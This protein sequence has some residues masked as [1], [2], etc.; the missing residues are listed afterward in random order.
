MKKTREER[1]Q[2]IFAVK[3]MVSREV[4]RKYA[5]SYLGIVW[6]VLNPLM[7]MAVLSLIFSTIFQRSIENYPIYYLTGSLFWHLFSDATSHG[8]SALVDNRAMLLKVKMS[9]QTFVIARVLTALTNF[10]Y[11]FVAYV[12]MLLVFRIR[13][14][15]YII[16]LPIDVFFMFMFAMG[17]TFALSIIYVFFADIKYLYSIFLQLLLYISAL[18]YPVD[19]LSETMQWVIRKNPVYNYIE[20]AR[21]IVLYGIMPEPVLWI[22][23]TLWGVIS[24]V[25]GYIFF[26]KYENLVMQK[27]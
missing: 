23:I 3:Q 8:M 24:F 20:F 12:I 4:K 26:K 15:V 7:S 25:I 16:F 6:S 17:I 10:G 11:S 9:K 21:D 19:R 27:I 5:R 22:K 14:T 2:Y 1:R 18:F 13:P